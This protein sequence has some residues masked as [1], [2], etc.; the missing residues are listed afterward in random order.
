MQNAPDYCAV[1]PVVKKKFFNV[2]TRSTAVPRSFKAATTLR[3]STCR[4][5]PGAA[6][7]SAGAATSTAPSLRA[8]NPGDKVE[9]LTTFFPSSLTDSKKIS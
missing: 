4:G 6:P 7:R 8:E 1:V 3:T 5:L 9:M 2:M